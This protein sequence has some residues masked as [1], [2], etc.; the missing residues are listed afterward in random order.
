MSGMV[1]ECGELLKNTV[2]PNNIEWTIF[3]KNEFEDYIN[4]DYF[5]Y[6]QEQEIFDYFWLCPKCRRLHIWL[7]K[8]KTHEETRIYEVRKC[9]NNITIEDKKEVFAFSS[10]DEENFGYRILIK[11][12]MKLCPHKHRYFIEEDEKTIYLY[13]TQLNII[14]E[15]YILTF[16]STNRYDLI[17]KNDEL[18]LLKTFEGEERY[19]D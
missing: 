3:T 19:F 9:Q 11:D 4:E 18:E 10:E 17:S 5:K 13:N 12:L 14:D 6:T 16:S 1:C 8:G 15:K 7:N 2:I